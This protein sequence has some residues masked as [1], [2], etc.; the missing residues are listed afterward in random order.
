MGFHMVPLLKRS[1]WLKILH[2]KNLMNYFLKLLC[3]FWKHKHCQ[4]G[5]NYQ[6]LTINQSKIQITEYFKSLSLKFY[7]ATCQEVSIKAFETSQKCPL[8]NKIGT[9]TRNL[10]L[11]AHLVSQKS[12]A[13]S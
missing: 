6:F 9:W 8:Y 11:Q 7:G 2:I 4:V 10:D 12:V 5:K 1:V 3:L 13:K